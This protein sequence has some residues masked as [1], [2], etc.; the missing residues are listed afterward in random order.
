MKCL[1]P[2][3]FCT[4]DQGKAHLISEF[5]AVSAGTKKECAKDL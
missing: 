5:S 3:K 1:F 4:E 2:G